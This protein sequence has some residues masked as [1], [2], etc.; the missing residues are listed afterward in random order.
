MDA[1]PKNYE[2]AYLISPEI[3]EDAVFGEAGKITSFIQDAH[4]MIGRIEEPKKRKLAYP[5]N[6][7]RSAYFGWTTLTI[8]AEHLSE[9]EK[10]L[11][12]EKSI[13]RYLVVEREV[14]PVR[15]VRS[16]RLP[17][18]APA[19]YLRQPVAPFVP[20]APKEEDKAKLEELDKQLEEILGK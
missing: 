5:I 20:Q 3:A 6:E 13:I 16:P 2:V 19:P 11:N 4:G 1:E 12:G 9:I 14:R 18:R 17:R 7:F 15:A 8:A 10:R